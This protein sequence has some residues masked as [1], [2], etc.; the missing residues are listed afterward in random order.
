MIKN[1][2]KININN[3]QN[4]IKTDIKR[5]KNKEFDEDDDDDGGD[6]LLG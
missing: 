5:I 1:K 3:I 2:L 4:D 6:M